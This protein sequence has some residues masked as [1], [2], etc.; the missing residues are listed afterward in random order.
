MFAVACHGTDV[1]ADKYNAEADDYSRIMAQALGDRLVEAFAELV[2]K[3]M[4]QVKLKIL[5]ILYIHD[6]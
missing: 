3:E 1:L 4:R 2:H 6:F 5:V